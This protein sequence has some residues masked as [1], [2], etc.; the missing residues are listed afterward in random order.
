MLRHSNAYVVWR[1]QSQQMLDF[2]VLVTTAA[3]QLAHALAAHELDSRAYLAT[4]PSFRASREPYSTEKRTLKEYPTVLGA[5][6]L[7]SIFS[8]FE[9]YF[10][11]LIDEVLQFHGGE[12]GVERAIRKQFSPRA[13]SPEA[14]RALALLRMNHNPGRAD[15]YRKHVA[16]LRNEPVLWPSQRLMLFGL[17]QV[18]AQ[19]KRWKSVHIPD[20]MADLLT[21]PVS[22]AEHDRFHTIRDQRNGIAHGRVLGHD[23]RKAV[24]ASNFFRELSLRLDTHVVENYLVIERY[25]H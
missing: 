21:Y 1:S 8:Y 11:S 15:Q 24:D 12:E 17:R 19:R 16:A 9:A 7:L 4:N 25:A 3:P 23:L 20:L 10:F 13:R 22:Q 18:V 14:D 2:A 6:L 5:T